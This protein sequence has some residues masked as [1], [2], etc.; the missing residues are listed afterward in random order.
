MVHTSRPFAMLQ[1]T[2]IA[3]WGW[4]KVGL[5]LAQGSSR[6]DVKVDLQLIYSKF[7]LI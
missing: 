4:E 5:E 2:G 1:A 6:V 7:G 3:V